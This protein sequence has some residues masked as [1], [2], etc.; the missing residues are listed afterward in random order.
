MPDSISDRLASLRSDVDQL[1][2]T[3]AP[4]IRRRGRRRSIAQVG[5]SVVAVAAL[6]AG[7]FYLLPDGSTDPG[8]TNTPA[9]SVSSVGPVTPNALLSAAQLPTSEPSNGPWLELANGTDPSIVLADQC[10]PSSQ[11]GGADPQFVRTFTSNGTEVGAYTAASESLLVDG[12]PSAAAVRSNT[13]AVVFGGCGEADGVATSPRVWTLGGAADGGTLV[14]VVRQESATSPGG[15]TYIAVARTGSVTVVTTLAITVPEP[16]QLD[17]VLG[18]VH[19][20]LAQLC[21]ATGLPCPDAKVTATLN[22]AT[23]PTV[24]PSTAPPPG[25]TPTTS[26]ST[27]QGLALGM[28]VGLDDLRAVDDTLKWASSADVDATTTRYGNVCMLPWREVGATSELLREFLPGGQGDPGFTDH[29]AQ[30]A[31]GQF[32]SAAEARDAL[33]SVAESV[34][35]C[36]S[37]PTAPADLLVVPIK[38]AAPDTAW[39]V[40]FPSLPGARTIMY[41]GV[42]RSGSRVALVMLQYT[43]NGD[44][45]PQPFVDLMTRAQVL[46]GGAGG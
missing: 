36:M 13:L 19:D 27:G 34:N 30:A 35:A 23:S 2:Y 33:K 18:L 11:F 3:P 1:P 31:L 40:S 37:S 14:E 26:E 25:S 20:A 32:G 10:G 41:T 8:L 44:L 22:A 39:V 24:G 28:Q 4:T 5:G 46:L 29:S 43:G 7:G 16:I 38:E 6:A 12:D 42:V 17:S 21:G 15:Y 9:P 45:L